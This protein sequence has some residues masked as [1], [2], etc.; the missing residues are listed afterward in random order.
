MKS[1]LI[2]KQRESRGEKGCMIPFSRREFGLIADL[3]SVILTENDAAVLI[4][5]ESIRFRTTE[6]ELDQLLEK[7]LEFLEV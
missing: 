2:E 4:K 5:E 6:K 1:T 3:A 7:I